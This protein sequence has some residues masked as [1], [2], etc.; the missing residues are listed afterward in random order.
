[1]KNRISKSNL[2]FISILTLTV[3]A[4][5]ICSLF[6][7][8]LALINGASMEPTYSGLELVIID[9]TARELST[10]DVVAIKCASAGGNIIKR[11]AA[12]GGDTLLISDGILYVNGESVSRYSIFK[13]AGTAAEKITVPDGGYFVIGDNIDE[14]RDSRYEEIGIIYS[15]NIIGRIIPQ[16]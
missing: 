7:Y 8:Q 1:M 5:L 12:V 3:T 9:K 2:I 16:K 10:G 14:S 4:C 13:Y 11:I 6:F 15:D